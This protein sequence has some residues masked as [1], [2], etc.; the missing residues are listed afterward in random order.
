MIDNRNAFLIGRSFSFVVG[1]GVYTVRAKR[2]R[3]LHEA[4]GHYVK[5]ALGTCL[6]V[7]N[8]AGA[9]RRKAGA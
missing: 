2:H 1:G 6:A 3:S 8:T 7:V 9:V 5:R 4:A